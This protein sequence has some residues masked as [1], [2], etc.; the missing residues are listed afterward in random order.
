MPNGHEEILTDEPSI[1]TDLINTD[2]SKEKSDLIIDSAGKLKPNKET[3][4]LNP[5][6]K[7]MITDY[8]QK[9]N[10]NVDFLESTVELKFPSG[11]TRTF[12][13]EIA[14]QSILELPN[15]Y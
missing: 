3:W 12:P 13:N 4:E 5:K 1:D 2:A 6:A 14:A 7:K 15:W 10:L 11:K 8:C 9:H